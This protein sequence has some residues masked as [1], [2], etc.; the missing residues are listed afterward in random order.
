ME[1]SGRRSRHDLF[2]GSIFIAIAAL[3][4]IQGL[5]YDFGSVLQ[6]GPGFFPV[7]LAFILAALG[8]AVILSGI[9][10]TSEAANGPAAWRGIVLIC[11]SLAIFAG[12]A[13]SL[14]LVPVVA[15]CT[16]LAARASEQNSI[17]SSVIM[18]A[19]LS[20]ICYLIFKVGLAVTLPTFGP[21]TGF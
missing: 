17:A 9:G 20:G 5:R 21:W 1:T 13:R 19:V 16:F 6:M 18:S 2:A 4:A 10:N 8:A 12:T 7:V 11:L 3:F 15:I 14:G